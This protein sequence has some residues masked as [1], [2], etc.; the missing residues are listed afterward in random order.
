MKTNMQGMAAATPLVGNMNDWTYN[1]MAAHQAVQGSIGPVPLELPKDVAFVPEPHWRFEPQYN[2]FRFYCED[3][4]NWILNSEYPNAD[5]KSNVGKADEYVKYFKDGG[6]R[7]FIFSTGG[8]QL[9]VERQP[10]DPS[11]DPILGDNPYEDQDDPEDWENGNTGPTAP[12]TRR[13]ACR[14]MVAMGSFAMPGAAPVAGLAANV[15]PEAGGGH[16]EAADECPPCDPG[17]P[18]GPCP[19]PIPEGSTVPAYCQ[20]KSYK[21]K[22]GPGAGMNKWKVYNPTSCPPPTDPGYDPQCPKLK[23]DKKLEHY[24]V[25]LDLQATGPYLRLN[26]DRNNVLTQ[27]VDVSYTL[28]TSGVPA[29]MIDD[30]GVEFFAG[31]PNGYNDFL[32][33]AE[34]PTRLGRVTVSAGTQRVETIR[35]PEAGGDQPKV[36]R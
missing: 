7:D 11:R 21:Y 18:P 19:A 23:D 6:S 31:D 34:D 22:L 3:F 10:S 30:V 28:E 17:P 32:F 1:F 15:M 14:M 26:V 35:Y 27:N 25:K 12:C 2:W 36:D 16:A 9:V 29:D 24:G 13:M 33:Y 8:L 4:E 5:G 20:H